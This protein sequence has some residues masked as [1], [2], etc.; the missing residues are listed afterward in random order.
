MITYKRATTVGELLTNYREREREFIGTNIKQFHAKIKLRHWDTEKK[1]AKQVVSSG[2]PRKFHKFLSFYRSL[3]HREALNQQQRGCLGPCGCC[4]LCGKFGKH[5]AN[6]VPK[7]TALYSKGKLFP[8]RQML[9]CANYRIYIATRKL[10]EEQYVGQTSNK[11]SK[12]WN[13]YRSLWNAVTLS[14]DQEQVPLLQHVV[15]QRKIKK[16]LKSVNVL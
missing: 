15:H 7:V 10:C 8:L 2:A 1:P 16:S 14:D 11:F 13:S 3:A 9:A 6:M 12:R 5:D 4:A